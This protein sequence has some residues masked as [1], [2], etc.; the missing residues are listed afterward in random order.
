MSQQ[1]RTLGTLVAAARARLA[2]DAKT[3]AVTPEKVRV[4]A[5]LTDFEGIPLPQADSPQ[6]LVFRMPESQP[7][8][9]SKTA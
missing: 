9:A 1:E 8:R 7:A 5:Q 2:A 3:G 4:L 6:A